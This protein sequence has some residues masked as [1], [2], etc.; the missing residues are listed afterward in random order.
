M[1]QRLVFILWLG[2]KD[3]G[4]CGVFTIVGYR[5]FG[6]LWGSTNNFNRRIIKSL[7]TH[8]CVP[9]ATQTH[10]HNSFGSPSLCF[11]SRLIL[12]VLVGRYRENI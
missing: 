12:N 9:W 11:V 5:G 7:T 8:L 4:S 2:G 10:M 1:L 3:L 6:V